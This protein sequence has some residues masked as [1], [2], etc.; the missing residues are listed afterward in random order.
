M[1]YDLLVSPLE[2]DLQPLACIMTASLQCSL[3]FT[4]PSILQCNIKMGTG[5]LYS[6]NLTYLKHKP[7]LSVESM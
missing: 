5:S 1:A 3:I 7:L 4:K 6:T 2:S